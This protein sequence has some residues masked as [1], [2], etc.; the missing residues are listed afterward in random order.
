MGPT[1][2]AALPGALREVKSISV[3]MDIPLDLAI[4][5]SFFFEGGGNLVY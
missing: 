1:A 5:L 2:P 4:F 3:E